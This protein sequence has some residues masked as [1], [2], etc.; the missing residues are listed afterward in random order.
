MAACLLILLAATPALDAIVCQG[1]AATS[2]NPLTLAQAGPS[3]DAELGKTHAPPVGSPRGGDAGDACPHG[4]CHHFSVF[5]PGEPLRPVRTA[6]LEA[7]VTDFRQ[8]VPTSLPGST[9]ERP[10]RA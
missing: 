4:H 9:P 1:D 3:V 7:R 8:S 2:A 5:V 10:P 6:F